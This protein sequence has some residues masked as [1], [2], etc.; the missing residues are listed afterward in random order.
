VSLR[1]QRG[2]RRLSPGARFGRPGHR[3]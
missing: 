3:D 2:D 1:A